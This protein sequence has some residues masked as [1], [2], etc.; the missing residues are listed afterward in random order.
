MRLNNLKKGLNLAV[1]GMM[2]L[3]LGASAGFGQQAINLS[4][5]PSSTMLPDGQTV[6]MWS[7]SCGAA[8]SGS[9]ATCA[10]LNPNAAGT[11]SPVIIT[12]PT[13]QG[14][15]INLTNALSFT[16]SNGTNTIPTSLVVVGQ[17][18]GGLGDP[19]QEKYVDSPVHSP[20]G[21]TW[22]IANTGDTFTP[23][24]QPQRVQSFATEV[25]AGTS[26]SLTWNNLRPG[27]Y[28]IESGTHPSIQ[29]P[30]GLYG[31][32]VVTQ[33]PAGGV[34]GTAYPGIKYDADVPLALGEID[35]VQNRSVAAAVNTAGFN[36]LTVWS[37][38]T[39]GCGN[40]T[41]PTYQT[42][43]PPAVNYTPLYYLINGISLDKN[44]T[45]KSSFPANFT[46]SPPAT[47]GQVLVRFVNAGS[48][49]HVPSIVGAVTGTTSLPGFALIAEDG[50]PLPGTPRVQGE[51]LLV[52]GKTY[53]VLIDP[54]ATPVSL[55]VYDR[56]LNLSA[57]NY[58][59]SGMQAYISI[60]G[61]ATPQPSTVA[62]ANPDSY[63]VVGNNPLTIPDR[64]RGVM[65][66]DVNVNGV[67]VLTHP[68]SGT[69]ILNSDGTFTYT[70]TGTF[71]AD[72]FT[73]CGNG[74]SSGAL[75]ATVVLG[76]APMESA[77]GIVVNN[78][79]YASNVATKLTINRPG[80]LANDYDTLGYPL[81]VVAASITANGGLQVAVN[82]DGSFTA[83]AGSAGT[84]TFTYRAQNSQGTQSSTAATVTLTFPQPSNLAVTVKDPKSGDVISD[85]RWIIEEDRT[86]HIEPATQTNTGTGSN[87]L[88]PVPSLGTNFHTSY[89]PIVAQGCVGTL[90]CEAG[91]S[92]AGSPAV[93]DVGDGMCRTTASQ[94][95]PVDP[96]Q[97][98]LDPHKRYYI[99]VL[100]GDAANPFIG[101]NAGDNCLNGSPDTSGTTP[102]DTTCGHAM[103]GA[104]IGPGQSAVTV[105]VE[106]A[107]LPTAKVSVVVFEDDNPV[108]GEQ[109]AGGGVDVLAPN[110][111]GLGGFEIRLFDAAG[112]TGDSTGQITY[113]MFN[114]PIS[115]S[116]AGTV[117]PSTGADACAI[118][119]QA[120]D[121][122][123][124]GGG[125]SGTNAQ[126]G[127]VGMVVTCP[128]YE[129]DRKTPSPLAGQAIIANLYPGRY[130]AQA[131]PGA[132]R[133]ARG[134]EWLQTNTLDGQKGHDAF[135]K[136]GGPGYFQEYGPASYH[137][138]IGFAN[139][140]II[141]GRLASEQAGAGPGHYGNTIK[142]KV[143]TVRLSR[144]PD[145]RMYSSG[146]R[147]SFAFTQCYVS[148]GDPDA[149]DFE[150][151]KCDPDGNFTFT[152]V[153]D[154]S[155]RVTLFDQWND[156]LLDG[157]SVPV[158]VTGSTTVDMGDVPVQQWQPNLY[159]RLF[160]DKNGDGVSQPEEA[161]LSLV[162]INNRFRDGSFSN[163]NS[164]DFNGYAAYNEVFPLFNWYVVE[165][166]T[167]R[168]KQTGVHVVLD[169]G[170]PADGSPGCNN[171]GAPPCGTST[172]GNLLANTAE[173]VHLPTNLRFPGSEYCA[174]ADCT[175]ITQAGTK[176]GTATGVAAS[177]QP[178]STSTGRIDPPWIF[179]EGW[180]EFPGQNMFLEFGKKPYASGENGGIK[181]DVV[182]ASTR[183]FDDPA[184]L[185]QLS[186]E[187]QVP[188]VTMNLYKEG[189]GP[190][191]SQ[192][193]TLIDTT[194]TS[195]WD[196]FAQG[197][198]SD[199]VP[200]MNCPG[201]TNTDPFYFSLYNTP[202]Y[203]DWYNNKFN[204]GPT[205]AILPVNGQ[206]K[207]YDGM[208]NW[209]QLQP[210]PYD[211]HYEFPSV[212]ARDPVTGQPTGTNCTACVPNTA[213]D[214]NDP[215]YNTPMLP[216]G[217]YVVEVVV[218]PGYE[219]VKEEDKNILI[220]DNYIAPA[221]QQFGGLG[222]I[223]ILPDQAAVAGTYN[224]NNPQNPTNDL[225][226]NGSLPR[227]EGDTGSVETYWPC[228]GESRVV[229]DY[230]SLF[231]GS[232]EVA[233][234]AGATR[235]LC[236]RKEVNLTDQTSALAKFYIFSSTHTAS[237]FTGIITDDFSSEF[238]PFAPSFGEKFSPPNM[239]VSIKDWN[240]NEINRIYADNWGEYDGLNYSTWE[241]NPPNPTG[242]APTMMVVC[243]NDSGPIPD[244]NNPGQTIVDPL[245]NPGYSQFCY[246]LPFMPGQTG[247]FDT[248]VVPTAAFSE[249]YNHP[250]C[251]YPDVTPAV[252]EVDGDV[253]GPWVAGVH[254][255]IASVNL[256]SGGTGYSGTPTVTFTAAPAGG[257][258]ATGT[259]I[260]SGTVSSVTVTNGGSGYTSAPTVNLTSGGGTGAT[261]VATISG[262]VRTVSI[263]NGGLGYI[264][265]PTVTFGAPPA[266]GITA[267][268]T[269]HIN[270]GR[271]TSVSVNNP[272][273][274]YTAAPSVTFSAPTGSGTK[275]TAKAI[276]TLQ[277]SVATVTVTNGG[278]GY[279]SAPHVGFS[280]GGG[281]GANATA[282]IL[283][284]VTSVVLTNAGGGY[285]T[286][287]SVTFSGGGGS[288]AAATASVST[289]GYL[290]I[291]A[292]GTVAVLNNA[293]SGPAATTAPFNA[294]TINR[295]YSFGPNQ[296]SGSVTIGG[297]NAPVVSWSDSQ[298]KVQV[299]AGLAPCAN[300]YNAALSSAQAVAAYGSCGQLVITAA[301]G[302]SSV[303][304]VTVTVGGKAPTII[305]GETA[306]NNALQTAIDHASP[307]DLL[308]VGPGYY[309]EMA[310]M[311]KPVRLQ[312]VGAASS[313]IDASPHPSG[314]LDPWR[315]QVVCLFGIATDGIPIAPADPIAGT[316]ANPFDPSGTYTCP[317][318]QQLQVDRIPLE[319]IVGWDTNLNGNLAQLLQEPTIMG[320]Y[321]GAG[322]TVLA[323]GVRVPAGSNPFS[324]GTALEGDFPAGTV[325]LTNSVA[326][327][328]DY[329]SNFLCSPSRIDGLTIT[330]SS[331]GGGG[332]FLHGWTHYMEISNNRIVNNAGTLS[333]GIV[334]GQG[335]VPDP[336]LNAQNIQ[337][338]YDL[339]Q[340]VH[341]HNNSIVGNTS[342]GDE[343]FAATPAAAGGVT[344]NN[345]SD[346]YEFK[347]N[348]LCGNMSAGD[349]GGLDHLGFNYGGLIQ[350]NTIIF[351]QS[352]NPTIPTNGGG[353]NVSG[354]APDGLV[355][356]VEC[357][358]TVLDADCPPGLSEGTGPGLVIDGNL[359][360]GNAAESGSGGGIRLQMVN[361]TEVSQFPT[362]PN[363]WYGV[364]I[365]NNI[366]S[367]NVAGWDGGGVSLQDALKVEFINNTVVANDTTASS[368]VL[369][370]TLGAP[371]AS[372]P[373]PGCDP[374]NL[375]SSTQN[376]CP[377]VTLSVPQP[378]GLVTLPNTSNLI[379]A[380]PNTI[381]CPIGHSSGVGATQQV[382]NGDCRKISYPRIVND[383]FWQ[384]RSFNI[385]VGSY[386]TSVQQNLVTLYPTLNQTHTG[387]CASGA[388]YWDIGVR[389]D[390]GPGTHSSTFT[391]NPTNSILTDASTHYTTG[392]NLASNPL[393]VSQYCN[394]A[395]VPPEN[396]GNPLGYQV[397]P[398]ISDAQVPNP[399]FSL[400]PAATVDEGN[401]W[402]NIQWGP[403][404]RTNA[405]IMGPNGNYGSGPVLGDYDITAAS[406]AIGTALA[407]AAPPTDFYGQLR[408][409][410][411]PTIGAVEFIPP[412]AV[413]P[414]SLAFG[415]V[416]VG[417]TSPAQTLTIANNTNAA[418]TYSV[419]VS[420]RFSVLTGANGGTCT[421]TSL[422][423]NSNCT[424]KVVFTPSSPGAVTGT[425]TV[426][427]SLTFSG[428]PVALTGTGVTAVSF[429]PSTW[430]VSQTRNCPGTTTAQRLACSLDPAQVF[431]LTNNGTV[432]LTGVTQAVLS[433]TN[434]SEFS[435]VALGTTCGKTGRTTLAANGGTCIVTVQFKP[436]TSQS[437]GTKTANVSVTDAAGTQSA[438]LTGHAN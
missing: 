288:G 167:T 142:G 144:T 276:S 23:P 372:T 114:M 20:Q 375:T 100:P 120:T 335:E 117:D 186:W 296:G 50:N 270:S 374:N 379:A 333:G 326:D 432:P 380:L 64:S 131:D 365:T 10:A 236:D 4:A 193:L 30:M 411:L 421:G 124:A 192:T 141:N 211:G 424:V 303:D 52:A 237:H 322:I 63:L 12:V 265:V 239:P 149:A 151:V 51:V 363:Q 126:Q 357:G 230:I 40:P 29:V 354:S 99:S 218:P 413:S 161:G 347:N 41:S 402:I 229:P 19:N 154:G 62:K 196:E 188:G 310:L 261:A 130:V 349:G 56:A 81:S 214:A 70:P 45:A 306:A 277:I 386:S 279:T 200:N 311:W 86:F 35:P 308:M 309:R 115:N 97:V 381:R 320:A 13:G 245:F 401:N 240:G 339:Q 116:L 182:Y 328:T 387:D 71:S 332:I 225:G 315:R 189:T 138:V 160:F 203:L 87:S 33:A 145:E 194:K 343:L 60:N 123:A 43:Y 264:S 55:P 22:P 82:A 212:T 330:D 388:N 95:L 285:T 168:Y 94:K 158:A 437:T 223:F 286:A 202:Q 136:V 180:Q 133:I 110:E 26:S 11:W 226:S 75:C 191:G 256:S 21:V 113:D 93:C 400:T 438:V 47:S 346:W 433:G 247:Y 78:D 16:T 153:P 408:S 9:A 327:C 111:P 195:S 139:P 171:P 213:T 359:I 217:K 244:P 255:S 284:S 290:T 221:T 34:Q 429:L 204:G 422:A 417:V 150:F 356:G 118:S 393:V 364:T 434:A 177:A 305:N 334:V 321:E 358:N 299:P 304:A 1:L 390:T 246:E 234:F 7:Y 76:A 345:G 351:N 316:P 418:V 263:Q 287:P 77:S 46:I 125:T 128:Y 166:D 91:Q 360:M 396:T 53:D 259:A 293:Y 112:G 291:K 176:P 298:I 104:P 272:G 67:A 37:G 312:G 129:S 294:K 27:T 72:S 14:L 370:N 253:T 105:L 403:L 384:N 435:I 399:I 368:G 352:S 350:H 205:P 319:G 17:L 331:Q 249:G 317:A 38:L 143:T 6:P 44:N 5:G 174:N 252:K 262:S 410:G 398:G 181:G 228:V 170:G 199:G 348:W 122:I 431:T 250:D 80:L 405:A 383:L 371:L 215:Y 216:D 297:I 147:D 341:V 159:T 425:A 224:P 406:P 39:G 274:G 267:T 404:S 280:G 73:Y 300:S 148:I 127:I 337:Q 283:R 268:G 329:P 353:I 430:T 132:D 90:A 366:I 206:F 207:C 107:P 208:H 198:R 281:S 238:D 415:S 24:A 135:I 102:T 31:I 344:F 140:K 162:P 48:R 163:F 92:V 271:V 18:G 302:K 392:N 54:P 394:G 108:N 8:V 235:N 96:S 273:S 187:P 419:A 427:G 101:G 74:A 278:M 2:A 106:P 49:M 412:A 378:A 28:L 85:Y 169:A 269:A 426:S 152:G 190:D 65:A 340:Y 336:T 254:G 157:L 233:P 121:G 314:K 436:L 68:S 385:G 155:W 137:D 355:N 275:A 220:G 232:Q 231:P 318:D 409:K 134:E 242:Y 391:L 420:A 210:A 146:S 66:N 397:P 3:L 361:G 376:G 109:D 373:P 42:C 324:G 266:G 282:V 209:N 98:Y 295:T 69:V 342:Y 369:F 173:Q 227:S 164:T 156:Q 179:S 32:L 119:K 241:V 377:A 172:I 243:M 89:M 382:T 79:S 57:N 178:G 183:P 201:Q 103:G 185:L 258:T 416:A 83:I 289:G 88:N 219:L 313:I 165:A 197:V 61:G 15:E 260:V 84:Y 36:E 175:D 367:D 389:G 248:P 325:V 323:K 25:A 423:A 251:D 407:S 414:S 338:P 184:L 257:T 222:D 59:D 307:G 58:H 362:Q 395:R 428:S 301:N 292:L